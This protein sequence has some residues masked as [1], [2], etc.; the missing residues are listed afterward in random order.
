MKT[1]TC[2]ACGREKAEESF[3]W[4]IKGKRRQQKCKTCVHEYNSSYYKRNREAVLART[5][6]DIATMR[7]KGCGTSFK[8]A[9]LGQTYCTKECRSSIPRRFWERVRQ[10]DGCWEW[11]GAKFPKGYGS[12]FTGKKCELA[13]RVSYILHYGAI[14]DDLWVLHRCDNPGCVR[15]DHLFLGNNTD[16]VRDM[17]AKG[18]SWQQTRPETIPRGEQLVQTKL[19][20]EKV[21]AI[22]KEYAQGRSK[23][24]LADAY[25]VAWKTIYDVVKRRS[26]RHVDP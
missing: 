24:S 9:S 13:H 18:R 25:G 2:T 8:P 22:R 1:K 3:G 4:Q 10:S 20:S 26:W 14:P 16:N 15:P 17:I 7:C 6:R 23:Q 5:V 21:R 11:M 12:L 19:T